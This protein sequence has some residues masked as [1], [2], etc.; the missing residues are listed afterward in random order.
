MSILVFS[1]DY[2]S[3]RACLYE[4]ETILEHHKKYP[5]HI[6]LPIFYLVE[7]AQIKQQARDLAAVATEERQIKWA[8]A[9]KKVAS[10]GGMPLK[11]H[12]LESV[13]IKEIVEMVEGKLTPKVQ[14]VSHHH[15]GMN[16]GVGEI[17]LW[18][19]DEITDVCMLMICGMGGIGKTTISKV[20]Y[21]LNHERFENHERF[22]ASSFLEDIREISK[23][24]KGLVRLQRKLL[25]DTLNKEEKKIHTIS[26][27]LRR[28]QFALEHIRLLLVLDDVDEVEQLD[29]ILGL[30][31]WFSPGSKIIITSRREDL[32][33]AHEK[34]E[35]HW[36]QRLNEHESL[37]L[38]SLHAFGKRVPVAS[39]AEH[40]KNKN[41]TIAILDGCHYNAELGLQNLIDRNLLSIDEHNK[42]GMHQLLQDMGREVVCEEAKYPEERTRLWCHRESF[43]ILR[44]KTGS[45]KI[46]GLILDMNMLENN[47]FATTNIHRR[48]SLERV[49]KET[50]LVET[51]NFSNI[52]NLEKLILKNCPSLVKVDESLATLRR[53]IVLNLK[54]CKSLRK[55]PTNIGMVQSL[56]E[57]I[58]S[59][60]SN[61]VA[62]AE[63]L[64]KLKSL[65]T[66]P[67]LK[68]LFIGG[69]P[70]RSL[71]HFIRYLAGL[72]TLDISAS[73]ELQHISWP[74]TTVKEIIVSDCGELKQ[75]TYET[76][77][78]PN[79][80][81]HGTCMSLNYVQHGFKIEPIRNVD[82]KVLK[83][84]GLS[85]L[86]SMASVEI[87]IANTIVWSKMKCPIQSMYTVLGVDSIPNLLSVRIRNKTMDLVEEFIPRCYG[88]CDID[89][90]SMVWLSH[91]FCPFWEHLFEQGDQ[92]E[93][94]FDINIDT[95]IITDGEIKECGVEFLYVEDEDEDEKGVLPE[96]FSTLYH[97]WDS[98][99]DIFQ[100]NDFIEVDRR[101]PLL[102]GRD[103]ALCG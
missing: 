79:R 62:A 40:S 75:I 71:P 17:N 97:F 53:L 13:F 101:K 103:N 69:N 52:R 24:P 63:E 76:S 99:M 44:D 100:S 60:C 5:G 41:D 25:S 66:L 92:V 18:L 1:K 61:L 32:L 80:I 14:N 82:S 64:G 48:H 57:L 83:N 73:P 74:S 12:Q 45:G 84:L 23:N 47:S 28:I 56:K 21:N 72:K 95:D 90:E 10:L 94:S 9:L 31:N 20:V 38:F 88:I 59:G 15:V 27:G 55:L 35:V 102:L 51:P 43:N 37:E 49:W 11:S 36:I 46:E 8:A 81:T 54:D 29:A 33:K 22:D 2:L 87:L 93:V 4:V 70:I 19:K 7:P 42:L 89:D 6:I 26:D 67:M 39:L 34:Y 65:K 91:W 16:Y 86:K 78:G 58:V 85:E 3:S 68:N 77:F 98:G 50:K 96:Y 30:R